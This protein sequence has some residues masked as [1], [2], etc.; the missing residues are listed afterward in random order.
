MKQQKRRAKDKERS[1]NLDRPEGPEAPV[2]NPPA[3]VLHPSLFALPLRAR[4]IGK[5]LKHGPHGDP[6]VCTVSV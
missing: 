2:G 6:V 4:Y 3:F 5:N 1:A